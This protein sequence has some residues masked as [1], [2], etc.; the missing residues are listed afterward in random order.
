M[1]LD[2]LPR[3][4]ALDLLRDA[5]YAGKLDAEGLFD[6]VFAATEDRDEAS[7]ACARRGMERMRMGL[8][9]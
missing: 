6:L 1:M 3:L 7:R 4:D 2:A 9:A 5:E 8:P